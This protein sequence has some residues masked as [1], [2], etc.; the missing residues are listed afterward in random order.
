MAVSLGQWTLALDGDEP[1]RRELIGGKAWSVARMQAL[2]LS[3]PAAFVVTTAAC[4]AYLASGSPPSELD[5]EI[6]AAIAWL[7]TKTGRTFGAGPRPLLVSVRSGAAISMPGM[8]DT[9]LN[10]GTNDVTETAL[11]V[12]CGDPGFARNTHKRFLDLYA[13]IVLRATAPE[14]QPGKDPAT[15]RA[16]IAESCGASVPDD[17]REQ[18]RGAVRAVFE[19]WNSRRARRYRQHHD[20]ADDLGTAV[21]VQAMVFGNLDARSGTGV[22]FSRNPSTG[23]A[24]PYG[25]YLPRAQGEDVV[26]GKFTPKPLSALASELPEA[27]AALLAAAGRL[28]LAGREV[29]DIEFTIEGGK[30]YFLQSRAAKLAPHAAVRIAVDLVREGLIDQE[31]ALKRITPDQVRILLSPR[32]AEAAMN[33]A[34]LLASGEAASPGVGIGVVV[35]DPDEAERRARDGEAVILAR[36]TTSPEDLHGM[37]AARAVVTEL[38]GSTSHAAVVGRALGLPCVVGC[39]RGALAPLAGRIVTVDGRA[40]KI[41]AGAMAVEAPDESDHEALATLAAWAARVSPLRVLPHSAPQAAEAVDLSDKEEAADPARIG[42]LLKNLR[43]ARG[44]RGGVLASDEGV[45]AAL[46]AGLEFI[47]AEPVLPPMLAAIRAAVQP[48]A[49]VEG[50]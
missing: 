1:P 44:A 22:L 36:A 20:I 23:E 34:E 47:V 17:V 8:M 7:E 49:E 28:E 5:G 15:W 6:E 31:A 43:G 13:Q 4:N 41:Y 35:G 18:L 27:H 33:G 9:V 38:G 11:G 12:E 39:G 26:S 45:R 24:K 14:F 19:S 2:G 3:T 29:Q 50:K 21:T 37:I 16:A 42:A 40:G 32:I 10:L 25:E 48:A 30:L 46:A